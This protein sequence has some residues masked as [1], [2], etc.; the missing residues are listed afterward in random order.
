MAAPALK[1]CAI[2]PKTHDELA[3][4]RFH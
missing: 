2:W 4:K 3:P 1:P